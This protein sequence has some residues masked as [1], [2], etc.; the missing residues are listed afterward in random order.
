[1]PR[2]R[3][4]YLVYKRW[5]LQPH[6]AAMLTSPP[7]F[8]ATEDAPPPPYTPLQPLDPARGTAMRAAPGEK[9]LRKI[10]A[11]GNHDLLDHAHAKV[12]SRCRLVWY[13]NIK[14]QKKDY[15]SSHKKVCLMVEVARSTIEDAWACAEV[16]EAIALAAE[17][18]LAD[19]RVRNLLPYPVTFPSRGIDR[20]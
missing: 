10:C 9:Y 15:H 13:C 1:V 5:S 18:S 11:N 4:T 12:C 19:D 16:D 17:M 2:S 3:E 6:L 20:C 8:D 7:T 14:C